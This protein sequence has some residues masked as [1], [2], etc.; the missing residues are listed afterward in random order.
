M[1]FENENLIDTATITVKA[2]NGGDGTVS[3]RREKFLPH[4]GPDG[5]DG[6]NGGNIFIM[7]TTAKNTL[8]EFRFKKHFKAENGKNGKPA[9]M[10]GSD[11]ED[12]FI[13]VPVG[14]VICDKKT[15]EQLADF[16]EVNQIIC[17]A[18]GGK[19]GKG[20]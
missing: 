7:S 14:T 17:V 13:K 5:G 6:G 10:T 16:D 8:N 15:G 18:R 19:G 2:G 3:F 20:N 4:G 1:A 9:K 11:G 12:V